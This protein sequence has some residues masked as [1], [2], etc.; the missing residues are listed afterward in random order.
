MYKGLFDEKTELTI[1][2]VRC[3]SYLKMRGR[4]AKF[5]AVCFATIS[6]ASCGN[7]TDNCMFQTGEEAANAYR[8]YLSEVRK[9]ENLSTDRLVE[10][11]NEWQTLRDSVYTCIAKDTT[12]QPHRHYE[13]IVQM[14]HDSLRVEFTRLALSRPRTLADVLFIREK[15]SQYRYDTELVQAVADAE[16]FFRSLDSVAPYDRSA[17][18]IVS[19]YHSFLAE[20]LKSGIDTKDKMLAFIKEEDRLFRSFLNHLPELA[21]ANLSAITS[22]TEK[23]CLSV[24]Q[25]AEEGKLSYRDALIY[26][27]KRTN[28]RVVLNALACRDDINRNKVKNKEQA[29]AYVWMLLQPYIA[30]DGFSMTAMSETEKIALYEVSDNTPLMI[31]NL[32]K[33]IGTDNDQWKALPEL[34]VKIMMI[35]M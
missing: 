32:N 13:S 4:C 30:M 33:I 28:R 31:A 18:Q 11:V 5:L 21:G 29:R 35:S 14:V 1:K 3:K 17:K 22:E 19:I 12:R 8:S 10:S 20:T 25:S 16:P 27:A 24:F 2:S 23:C 34:L 9:S 7:N 15:T 6:L 26:T